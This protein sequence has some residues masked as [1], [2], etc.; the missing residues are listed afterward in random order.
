MKVLNDQ[1]IHHLINHMLTTNMQYVANL[2]LPKG[3]F[4]KCESFYWA[5]HGQDM[6]HIVKENKHFQWVIKVLQEKEEVKDKE[7]ANSKFV[8]ANL[9][10]GIFKI[11]NEKKKMENEL[12]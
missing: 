8:I 7:I 1:T 5:Q 11:S 3:Q 6:E 2:A 9:N 12:S 10:W 4:V